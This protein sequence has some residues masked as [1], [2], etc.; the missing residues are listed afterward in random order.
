M[1][2]TN[3]ITLKTTLSEDLELQITGMDCADCALNLERGVAR[4]Q[5][6][7]SCEVNFTA[8]KMRITGQPDPDAVT[9]RI[10]A[11]GYDVRDDTL[12]SETVNAAVSGLPGL[13][14]FMRSRRDTS[15]ALIGSGLLI[16]SGVLSLLGAP[17]LTISGLHFVIVLLAGTPIMLSG[18][19]ELR[20]SRSVTI[21]LLMTIATLGALI[22]GETGEA[23]TVIVLF[24]IG[25]ALEGYAAERARYSLRSLLDLAPREATALQPC[26][27][28][29]EHLGQDGYTGGP[30]PFC[31]VH[32][33]RV[34]V[35]ELTIGT[36]VLVRPGER[37]PMDGAILNGTSAVNQAPITGESVPVDKTPG[38]TVYAGT[39]NGSGALEIEVTRLAEDNTLSRIIHMV[40]EAQ[41]SKAPSQRFIDRFAQWYTPA[42]VILA[43]GLAFIPPLAF[44]APFWDTPE[45]RGWLYRALA[46][47]IIACPCALV[48]ST[49]VTIVSALTRAA[50]Q[51]ILIKGGAPLE[52]LA[53]IQAFAFDKT[54]T[55]TFGKPTLIAARA[56]DCQTGTDDL[57][58]D[59]CNDL[60]ALAAAVERRSEHPLAQAVVQAAQ[61]RN[62]LDRYTAA[63]DVTSLAGRGVRGT[64]G[65]QSITLG[66]H[67]YFERTYPHPASLCQTVHTYEERGQT[68]VLLAADE[69]VRGIIAIADQPRPT[70]QAALMALQRLPRRPRTVMLTGDNT[71]TARAIADQVGIDE[72]QAEMLPDQKL[73]AIRMLETQYGP[74]AM[75]GDGIND[76][77]ALAAA[78][79][80]IAMGGAG[81]AQAM[82]TADVVLMQD[83]LTRLPDALAVSRRTLH[84]IRE[85]VILS[86]GMKGVFL[87]LTLVG[88]TSLWLAVFA[89]VGASLI[90]TANGMRLLRN[91]ANR[92]QRHNGS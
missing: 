36:T 52:A 77:P 4:L 7:E 85:N 24:A 49:P 3:S 78:S 16:L 32:E 60:L 91:P 75:I 15:L 2:T 31:G 64:V 33:T 63:T 62:L 13:F 9:D 5:G 86:L 51:G 30:C 54:G 44:N 43:L 55:L 34:P 25:E 74:T 58:C 84:T 14:Q 59:P 56:V 72:V 87:A 12:E 61:E 67:R 88:A 42:V 17:G 48:I 82:E 50:R 45:T 6:V 39:I 65:N 1:T 69:A 18:W 35:V 53:G 73:D 21:N 28:C 19:R 22:I 40:E 47:L 8:G 26:M 20:F 80:G 66:S 90:V 89:D 68:A 81:S 38:D 79:V 46:L 37:I 29:G 70:S 83:D 76:A 71:T 23:A 41:A 27:D 10:R 11:L 92:E 57:T